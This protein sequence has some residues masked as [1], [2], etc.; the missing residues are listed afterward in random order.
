MGLYAGLTLLINPSLS[1]TLLALFL[2][3]AYQTAIKT[4]T[5]PIIQ[6]LAAA[7][8]CLLIFAPWPIRNAR[9]FHAFIPLRSNLGFELWKGNRP[10]ATTVDEVAVYPVFNRQEY[11]DYANRGEIGYMGHKTALAKQYIRA[12][13]A[14][15]VSLSAE[16]FLRYWTGTGSS[17]PSLFLELHACLTTILGAFGLVWLFRSR[18]TQLA[19]TLL[20]PLLL[21]PLPYYITHAEL[22]F[23]ILI[24][25][26]TTILAAYAVSRWIE[27]RSNPPL[28]VAQP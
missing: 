21:F 28:H 25:P 3:S 11:D 15:F 16:R 1:L 18:R 20:L 26:V 5:T 13:P 6:P 12:H 19:V 9:V 27:S 17:E 7:L 22:R 2:W 24:E 10:G 4:R 23:R 8:L 14:I